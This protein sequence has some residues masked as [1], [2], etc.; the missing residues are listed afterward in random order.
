[1]T[2]SAWTDELVKAAER[3]WHDG[4]SAA[5]IASALG[6]GL[7]RNAVLGKAFRLSWGERAKRAVGRKISAK[8][9]RKRITQTE[10]KRN[11]KTLREKS[12]DELSRALEATDLP[13]DAS[14]D[15]VTFEL[16]EHHHCRWP[17]GTPGTVEFRFCGAQKMIESPYCQRHHRIA[18]RKP[19]PQQ[20]LE[21]A[22]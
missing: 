11:Q 5:L 1:M 18:Y 22:E 21:A 6:N 9:P 4:Q 14:A 7:T 19:R 15:A 2:Q 10:L 20:E 12:L 17:M 3:M 13:P 8:R 16:L